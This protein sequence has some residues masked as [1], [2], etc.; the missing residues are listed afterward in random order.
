MLR[1]FDFPRF[2]LICCVVPWLALGLLNSPAAGADEPQVAGPDGFEQQIRPLIAT[3]CFP[4]HSVEEHKGGL[5]LADRAGWLAG[6]LNGSSVDL[7]QAENSLVLEKVS[8]ADAAG[9]MPPKGKGTQLTASEVRLLQDWIA[10]GAAWTGGP[11]T[12]DSAVKAAAL[13]HWS[14]R[15]PVWPTLP[16]VQNPGWM[17]NSIDAFVLAR[18]DHEGLQ[19]SP[20]ADRRTLARRLSLDLIGLPPTPEEVAAFEADSRPDAYERLVDRLI[21]SPR[22]G[23]RWARRWLDMARYADTNGFE[24]DRDRPIWP[25]RNWVIEALNSD[26]PFD[27][28]TI[29][30]VAGDLIPNATPAQK[31]ATGYHRNTM[32]NEEGGIDVE[33][34]R[35]AS[36][37]D[38][39]ANTGTAWLGLTLNC[40][41]CHNHKYDPINQNEYYR[42][43]AFLD[44]VDEPEM[45]VPD[46][47]REAQRA[48]IEQ[49]I[50]AKTAELPSKF[51]AEDPE[52]GWQVL[53]PAGVVAADVAGVKFATLGDQS[54]LVSGDSPDKVTYTLELTTSQTNPTHL[55]L[56]ALTDAGLPSKGPGRTAHGNFVLTG[57]QVQAEPL[58]GG[59]SVAVPIAQATADLSQPKFDPAGVLDAN[60]SSGWAVDE[61]SGRLNTNHALTLMLA[62]PLVLPGEQGIRLI[63]VLE[64]K[65]GGNHTL[66]RFKVS[67]RSAVQAGGTDTKPEPERRAIHLS[68]KQAAWEAAIS[69]VRWWVVRPESMLSRKGASL[70]LL[71]DGS[72]LVSGD[73][74]N[75]DVT[76]LELDIPAQLGP[77]TA[78]RL[79]VLPHESHPDGGPGRAPLFS[80]GDFILTEV[81]G[82]FLPDGDKSQT[83]PLAFQNATADFSQGGKEVSQAIDGKQD[84]GWSIQGGVGKPHHAVFPLKVPLQSE[85]G[86]KIRLVLHQFGIHQMTIGRFRLAV[87]T[88][89]GQVKATPVP[90]N[91]EEALLTLR[92]KRSADQVAQILNQFV[93]VAPELAAAR[94]EIAELRKQ[95]PAPVQTLVMEERPIQH[96]RIT[97]SH[98]RGEFLK[99]VA[100]VEPGVPGVLHRLPES[101]PVNRLAFARWLVDEQN[102]LTA[103]VVVNRDWQAFFGRGLVNTVE[104]FGTRGERPTHPELLD[105]L[106]IEFQRSGWSR[107]QLHRQIVTSATY[108]QASAVPEN[109]LER[110]PRNE[111]LARGARFRVEAEVVRDIALSAAG[112]LDQRMGG[113]SVYPPQPAAATSLAYNGSWPTSAGSDRYRRGLYTFV[114]RT[115]PYAANITFDGPTSDI[116]CARRE[117]SNTPLQAL[118]LLNDTVFVDA[119]RELARRVLKETPGNTSAGIDRLVQLCLG[120][121]ADPREQSTL[122]QF[123]QAQLARMESGELNPG[124]LAGDQVGNLEPKQL[125][126]WTTLARVVLNLDETLTRE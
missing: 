89:G 1:V 103:R 11:I 42:L 4:C 124:P 77:V 49:Q 108:K 85:R 26:L 88:Q 83:R 126:A 30:Q 20:E 61:G 116:T 25:Y 119:A 35:F 58:G 22:Y 52:E 112:L 122:A 75:N 55:R 47:K 8:G 70:D 32:T 21:D 17:R 73:K 92:A 9:I 28:F 33:E 76:E 16:Q 121:P 97:R 79:E 53:M 74:P 98:E 31:I 91:V 45:T 40:A 60:D 6:G 102:P 105:W 38:R 78:I 29:D 96:K 101:E 84:T 90:A 80:V 64:Q 69:P 37:V 27:Q 87:T 72:V 7:E 67:G 123:L 63:M 43:M 46:A 113:P 125:A 2:R 54:V 110:D 12:T 115:A 23:E 41:Q 106:A 3:R 10:Q 86:G 95:R 48:E 51:P 104:D 94:A 18:L 15:S 93:A 59:A 111:L 117:R 114:K 50:V 56:E 57:V 81:E 109:L 34:F 100:A 82:S 65:Y 5:S 24:K 71:P 62:S 39:V 36:L 107:K 66:G 68:R 14:F 99:P 13:N 44:N 118:T 120:R 19:P